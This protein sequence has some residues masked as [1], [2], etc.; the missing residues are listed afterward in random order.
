MAGSQIEKQFVLQYHTEGHICDNA[1]AWCAASVESGG[2]PVRSSPI[3]HE[4][5]HGQRQ[6][7]AT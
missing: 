7:A 3:A 1:R 5:H 4:A 6:A 2:M